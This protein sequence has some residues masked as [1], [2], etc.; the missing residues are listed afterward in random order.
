MSKY[1]TWV[2]ISDL[3]AGKPNAGWDAERVTETLVADLSKMEREQSLHPNFIFFTGDAAFGQFGSSLNETLTGQFAIAQR[4]FT[5]VRQAF[6]PEVPLDDL[7]LVPGNHDLN[8]KAVA[9]DQTF[10]LDKQEDQEVINKLIAT[11]NPQWQR[12]M[13]RFAAYREF[14][15]A[16]NYSHL[17]DDPDRLIYT[18][19]RHA[20]GIT[21]GIGGFNTA[22]SCCRDGE[23][24]Q[25]MDG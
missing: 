14:L 5:S 1:I 24:I 18:S 9:E 13:E 23:K 12:Y 17:L 10:W 3:H 21:V 4:F 19:I 2:H 16:N 20:A 11:R 22:W 15:G 6:S 8:R 7:F 25:A